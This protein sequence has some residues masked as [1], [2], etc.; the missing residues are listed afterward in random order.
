M[1]KMI[2]AIVI[3]AL[4]ISL[5]A[6]GNKKGNLETEP[7]AGEDEDNT[8]FENEPIDVGAYMEEIGDVEGVV[9]LGESSDVKRGTY[10]I[11]MLNERGFGMYPVTAEYT[12][13]GEYLGEEITAED[14]TTYPFYET[15]YMSA[16]GEIWTINIIA[17][18]I[19]AYPVTYNMEGE[20]DVAII[21][22]ESAELTSYDC[23]ANTFYKFTPDENVI[24]VIVVGRIEASMLDMLTKEE[25][26]R[27]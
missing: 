2:V 1:K 6:C 4:T 23:V 24:F 19:T 14:D 8:E 5:N 18:T 10:V 12:M 16:A 27:Y 3:L 15:Y 26:D 7:T 20:R 11:E 17:G 9:Q 13:D 21:F 25:M 22:S